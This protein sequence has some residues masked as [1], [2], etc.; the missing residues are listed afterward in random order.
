[1]IDC[2]L[3]AWL[4][5]QVIKVVLEGV[6]NRRVDLRRFVASGGMPS[7]ICA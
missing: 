2:A 7:S 4:L 5:A 6:L 3:L 1:M